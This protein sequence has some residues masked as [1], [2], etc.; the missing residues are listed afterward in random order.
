MPTSYYWFGP[1][2]LLFV[3]GSGE[4][5]W[6]DITPFFPQEMTPLGFLVGLA[7]FLSSVISE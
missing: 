1:G 5:G 6:G 4:Q 2:S 7:M 3:K